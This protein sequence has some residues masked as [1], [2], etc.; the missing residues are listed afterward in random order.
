MDA[1]EVTGTGVPVPEGRVPSIVVR[2]LRVTYK[3]YG[4]KRNALG[5]EAEG[6]LGRALDRVT[7]HVGTITEVPAVRGVSF[8]AYEGESI[9]VIG[10]NGSGKSTMLRAIAGLI[11][12]AG[13]E[14]WARG[15]IALMGVNAAL[16]SAL[17]GERNIMLG[18][19]AKGLSRK[20]VN[21][22]HDWIVDFAG[23]GD[24]VHLPMRT[25]SS[26]MA[27]RLRFAISA[28][29]APDIL[30]IDEALST[31]DVEFRAKSAARVEEI[32]EQAGTV[33]LVSHSTTTVRKMC[34]RAIWIDRGLLR[35]DGPTDEV[36]DHYER[37]M[38][39]IRRKKR[40][41]G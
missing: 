12:T 31:G 4:G 28:S 34:D 16:S 14:V 3:A 37:V 41:R 22:L 9:G 8:A 40:L 39:A 15:D 25:Y 24:F 30:I 38:R 10:R 18:G 23:I 7:R 21:E 2:D 35:M 6:R 26:G 29:T 19:L 5:D 11:P 32:R 36:C 20:E 33:F 27:A 13:G 17:S 1:T